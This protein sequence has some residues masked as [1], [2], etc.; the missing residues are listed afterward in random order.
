MKDIIIFGTGSFAEVARFYFDND[1]PYNVVAYTAHERYVT[2][3]MYDGLPII[4]FEVL[5][6]KY[7]PQSHGMF[8]AVGYKGVNRVRAGI[9]EEVRGS[10]F[11]LVS[12]LSSK[13]THWGDTKIGANCFIF[14]NNTI[15]PFVTIGDDTVLWSGNHIGHHSTIGSHCFITSQV[16][17]SGHVRVGDYCFLGVNSTLRDSIQIGEACVIGAGALIMKSTAPREV[18]VPQRTGVHPKSSDELNM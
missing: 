7:P 18:Y 6:E 9:C 11:E 16:V 5:A 13:A 8:V 15:Q 12:Y 1:S 3:D 2:S 14:E 10:G 4:P 17:V